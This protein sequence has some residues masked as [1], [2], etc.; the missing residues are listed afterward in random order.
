M[1]EL[2]EVET[3]RKDLSRCLLRTRIVSVDVKDARVLRQPETDFIR[4]LK[5][6]TIQ[7]I[8][9]RGKALIIVL[10]GQEFLVVQ[11][12]MT[13]QL[14][15]DGDIEKHTRLVFRLDKGTLLYNDQRVFGQLRVVGDLAQIPHLKK[16]GPEPFGNAFNA[17]YVT[18]YLKRTTRA[19]K[20]VLLDHV[21]VAGIGN[22]YASEILFRC[23]IDPLRSSQKVRKTEIPRLLQT[24]REVLQEAIDLRGSSM[25]NYRDGRGQKGNFTKAIRVYARNDQPCIVCQT[26]IVRVVQNGRSTFYCRKCQK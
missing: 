15:V 4:R 21:F 25:R 18:G 14:V 16:L 17:D 1:P 3:I 26:P 6:K 9:R 20:A 8:E 5:G 7:R 13:G 24:T 22:I 2:P 11:V 12:M 23:G 19:I 10:S